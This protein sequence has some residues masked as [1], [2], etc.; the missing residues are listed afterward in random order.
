LPS[1]S[2][3][4]DYESE[5]KKMVEYRTGILDKQGIMGMFILRVDKE[6]FNEIKTDIDSIVQSF[7]WN[8]K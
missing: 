6:T 5:D 4:A 8:K 3:T 2:Y 1:F 7:K